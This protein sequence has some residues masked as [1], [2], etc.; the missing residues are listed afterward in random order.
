MNRITEIV[1]EE[2]DRLD[3]RIISRD[4]HHSEIGK[5]SSC[6]EEL[7]KEIANLGDIVRRLR[8]LNEEYQ[9]ESNES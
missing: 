4:W 5:H 3:R 1:K 6:I 9:N 8:N 2:Q 7:D